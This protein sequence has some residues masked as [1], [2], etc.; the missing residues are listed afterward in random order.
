MEK[1]TYEA[2]EVTKVKA[3]LNIKEAIEFYNEH[4]AKGTPLMTVASLSL[5]VFAD[6]KSKD[7]CKRVLFC[8]IVNG[9]RRFV[10]MQWLETIAKVTGYPPERLI[11]YERN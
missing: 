1:R 8:Q 4:R 11:S 9:R 10:D 7:E 3:K 6:K 5:I 2:P